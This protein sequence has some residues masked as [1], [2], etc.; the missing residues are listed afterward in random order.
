M[1]TR[2]DLHHAL[3]EVI[4]CPDKGPE[5]R[6]YYQPPTKLQYPCIVYTLETA[7]TKFADNKP[8]M[9]RKRYQVTVIDKNPDSSYPDI[10]AQWPLCLFDRTY[11]A[12][13]LNHFVF[14]IYY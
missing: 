4:G 2:L 14:N 10:I 13:N 8:Y 5:C 9:Q 11:K 7:D 3:C 1:G 6:C 12:D